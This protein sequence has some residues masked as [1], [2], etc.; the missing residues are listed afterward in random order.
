[1]FRNPPSLYIPWSVFVWHWNYLMGVEEHSKYFW[2]FKVKYFF[3]FRYFICN[4]FFS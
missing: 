4:L 3:N 2:N 1:M